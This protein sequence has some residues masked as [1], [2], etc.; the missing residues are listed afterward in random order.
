MHSDRDNYVLGTGSQGM[1]KPTS[2]CER[3]AGTAEAICVDDGGEAGLG[4]RQ[5]LLLRLASFY[6][7]V[8][9]QQDALLCRALQYR[10]SACVLL[11]RGSKNLRRVNDDNCSITGINPSSSK[12]KNSYGFKFKEASHSRQGNLDAFPRQS[13]L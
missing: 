9:Y 5:H 12:R 8:W 2:S 3:P 11:L 7:L 6:E 4:S 10:S 13:V 1:T